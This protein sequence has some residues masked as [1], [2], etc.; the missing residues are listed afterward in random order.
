MVNASTLLGADDLP[1][2][3]AGSGPIPGKIARQIAQDATWVAMLIDP[4]T[5]R[6]VAVSRTVH[7][8]GAVIDPEAWM[9]ETLASDSYQPSAGLRRLVELR[10]EHCQWPGCNQPAWRC[11]LDHTEEFTARRP[12]LAQTRASN[13]SCLCKSHHQIK[14]EKIVDLAR[15]PATGTATWTMPSGA[16]IKVQPAI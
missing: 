14:T 11:E 13:L 3:L 1:A 7:D 9:S 16:S 8:P 5:G 10:D 2:V 6:K 12:A 15:D 4:V